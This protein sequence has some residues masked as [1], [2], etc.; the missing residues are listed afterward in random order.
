M[1]ATI[2]ALG[3]A[4]LLLLFCGCGQSGPLYLP[5]DPS[6]VQQSPAPQD[7]EEEAADER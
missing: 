3:P 1:K 7:D 6:E 4:M 2:R 5:D